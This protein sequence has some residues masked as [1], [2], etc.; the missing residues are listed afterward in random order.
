MLFLPPALGAS[1]NGESV[2][3]VWLLRDEMANLAW[4]IERI[5]ESRGGVRL[6]RRDVYRR[7]L[8]NAPAPASESDGAPLT[9]RLTTEVPEYWIP[10]VP[11]PQPGERGI[12]LQR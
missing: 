9:Y 8:E 2:E 4:G 10:L 7:R 1:L 12:R 3:E 11:V 5:V 6:D